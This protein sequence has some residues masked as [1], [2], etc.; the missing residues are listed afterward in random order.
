MI[1]LY[2]LLALFIFGVLILIHELGHFL[3]A[4]ACGVTVLEF[5]IG[6]GPRIVSFCPGKRRAEKKKK[7]HLS[8]DAA[9][10]NEFAVDPRPPKP[11]SE[12]DSENSEED[13]AKEPIYTT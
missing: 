2:I 10:Q 5:A 1:V 3:A 7:L 4:R 6:M 13:E 9:V 12:T 8:E 11:I